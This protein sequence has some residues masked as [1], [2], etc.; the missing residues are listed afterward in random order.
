MASTR[1]SPENVEQAVS[2][3][4]S[5]SVYLRLR[6]STDTFTVGDT[7]VTRK[8]KEFSASEAEMI[9]AAAKREQVSLKEGRD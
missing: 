4:S 3:F 5:G 8:L 7:T 6:G 1:Q 2:S 9:K